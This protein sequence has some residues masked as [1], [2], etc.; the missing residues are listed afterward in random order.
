VKENSLKFKENNMD[1]TELLKD[2]DERMGKALAVLDNDLKGLRT[3][4]ASV[5]LL[6]P[7]M[8]EAYGNKMPISQLATV[9][10]PDA[11]NVNVQVWDKDMVKTVEK[12]I[13]DAN[14][15]INT[16]TDGQVIRLPIPPLSEERRKDL[17]KLAHKYAEN[18]KVA[19]RN[20]RR[21]GMGTSKKMEKDGDLSEDELKRFSDEIQK[22]TDSFVGKIDDHLKS[23]EQEI[24]NI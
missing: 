12:A 4:R 11:R 9:T 1:K 16:A 22:L 19:V 13:A 7:V 21:D 6:D 17:V 14:L 24:L 8:V 2:L 15:G 18:S 3:G 23:K 5:N 20:I 10:T